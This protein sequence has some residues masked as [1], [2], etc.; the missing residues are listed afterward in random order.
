MRG[1]VLQSEIGGRVKCTK[2]D[3]PE[4][5]CYL[6]QYKCL[7]EFLLLFYPQSFFTLYDQLILEFYEASTDITIQSYNP[8]EGAIPSRCG[9]TTSSSINIGQSPVDFTRWVG[10]CIATNDCVKPS[11]QTAAAVTQSG[12]A[13][14]YA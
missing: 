4:G 14:D 2:L 1:E 13:L 12:H 7:I 3:V 6:V 5:I 10:I 9:L 11:K 8:K